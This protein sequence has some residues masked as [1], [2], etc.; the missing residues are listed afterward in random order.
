M[1]KFYF[2]FIL[3][4]LL[5]ISVQS[6][7][8]RYIIR[9][10]DKNQSGF[11]LST[12]GAYLSAKAIARRARYNIA[13]DSTDLPVRAAYLDSI[14]A[15]PNVVILN[16]S[17]WLNQVCIK[18]TD[19]A[20]LVKINAFSFVKNTAAIAVRISQ[21]Q[22]PQPGK[23][24]EF[25]QQ[26]IPLRINN[27]AAALR[28]GGVQDLL[29][30]GNNAGQVHIHEG[31]YL[32]NLGFRGEGMTIA[33]LDAGFYNYNNNPAFDSL[34][35]HNQILGTWDYVANEQS[36]S[37]DHTHGAYCLSIMAANEPGKI[38]GTAS[39][40]KYWL[41]RTE[42]A[43]SEYPVEEENWVAAAEFADSAGVDIITS[44]L[45]YSD[46]DDHSFDHS[47]AQRDGKTAMISL[48]AS[49]AVK[50][51]ILV[52]N[53][54]GNSGTSGGD[55][56]F[57]I[58]PADAD[59]VFTIGSTDVNGN[60]SA[61]SSWGPNGAGKLKPNV[62]S[63]GGP[64][65]AADVVTGNPITG[66]G[67][68]FSNPNLCGLIACLWQAFPEF[69]NMEVIDALQKSASKYTNPD[70]RYGY[71]IPNMRIAYLDLQQR[72]TIR[73]YQNILGD[74][75]LKAY[76]VP[77]NDKLTVLLQAPV[78]GRSNLRLVDMNGK[79]IEIKTSDIQKGTIYTL[80]FDRL[81][82]IAKGVYTVQ[83]TDGQ[84]KAFL[85]VVKQ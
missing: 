25:N 23:I 84:N 70:N 18:T 29:N 32:H 10:K 8:S 15:V 62:V 61:F 53:S 43:A 56:K 51:G 41:L 40:A 48:G 19:P 44:S 16:V 1:K 3:C 22:H 59:S 11:S 49:L 26:A 57:V 17:K 46:F 81:K 58:C 30:Y 72:S 67:T 68:S 77:F 73:K 64:A 55:A 34:R 74:T 7:Y 50:K 66:N 42:D 52:T 65:V 9:L 38:V 78:T 45:G 60:I 20:A 37:E 4:S 76:P 6:Q 13:I 5:S 63:V 35:L 14:K 12:P 82:F 31:E 36:V 71:G 47:Y 69:S 21:G 54:A 85:Q 24:V 83:Y 28:I 80:G 27:T 2:F 33:M 79:T 75:W 39:K